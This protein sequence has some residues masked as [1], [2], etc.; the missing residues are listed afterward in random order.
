MKKNRILT[1]IIVGFL[2]SAVLT[3]SVFAQNNQSEIRDGFNPGFMLSYCLF[4]ENDVIN[5]RFG[6]ES[7]GIEPDTAITFYP[8][9]ITRDYSSD[10]YDFGLELIPGQNNTYWLVDKELT[11]AENFVLPEYEMALSAGAIGRTEIIRLPTQIEGWGILEKGQ[12]LC[13]ITYQSFFPL[14]INGQN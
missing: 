6:F 12:N 2:F 13:P 8:Y 7:W 11:W 1:I 3:P 14:I 10:W 4:E 5:A 9:D